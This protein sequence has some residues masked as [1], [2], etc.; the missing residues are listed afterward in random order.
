MKLN[1]L[2]ILTA[3]VAALSSC[4]PDLLDTAPYDKASSGSMW[5]NENLCTMGVNAIYRNFHDGWVAK[6]VWYWEMYS[7]GGSCRDNDYPYL[8]GTSTQANG[9]FSGYWRS[10]YAG[11]YQSN[12]AIAH[13]QDA[14]IPAASK[15]RL[16]AEA[17]VLRAFFYYKLNSVFRGVPYYDTAFELDEAKKPRETE[18]A[19][20]DKCIQD[21]TEAINEPALPDRFKS[22]SADWGRMNK[23]IAYALRGKVNLWK[24]EWAAAEADFRKL[25]EMGHALFEGGYKQLFKEKNEQSDEAILSVQCIDNNGEGYANQMSFRYGGRNALQQGWNTAL[26][27][28]DFVDTYENKDGSRFDWADYIEEWNDLDVKDREVFFL[29]NT[30][31]ATLKAE[32]NLQGFAGTDEELNTIIAKITKA[33]NDRL[34]KLSAEAKALYLPAGNEARVKAAYDNRDPRLKA[35]VFTPYSKI[36][37]SWSDKD[38]VYTSRWPYYDKANDDHI[39]YDYRTDTQTHLYYLFRKFVAEGSFEFS[40]RKTSP[41]DMPIIRYASCL[42][43]LA[44]ALNEQGKTDEAVKVLNQVRERAGVALLNTNEATTVK[45][46]DDMRT[47]IQNEFRWETAGEGVDFYEEL[48]WNTYKQSK[49]NNGGV[50]GMKDAWGALVYPLT[51]GGDHFTVW[52][53]P[54]HEIDMNPELTQNTGWN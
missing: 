28:T 36:L 3:A 6:D 52:P 12:D 50:A 45:G 43:Y 48:R 39:P 5:A 46:Q 4:R 22:G 11:I 17:K 7:V 13:L 49:F 38:H 47:R 21:L 29:R 53:I 40:N 54:Q 2:F 51:W 25:G 14:A 27:N 9:L 42:I 19:I 32:M 26:V 20:W 23:S 41:I 8:A 24:K 31:P 30:D 35:T 15:A 1:K 16:I 34:A 18:S 10:H 44:E 33:V 37:G